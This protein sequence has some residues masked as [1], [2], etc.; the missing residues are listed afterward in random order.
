MSFSREILNEP[1]AAFHLSV[2]LVLFFFPET[3]KE[4]ATVLNRPQ[5]QLSKK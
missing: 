1:T 4:W 3:K 5:K 2:F